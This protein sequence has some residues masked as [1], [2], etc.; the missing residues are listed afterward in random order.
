MSGV[1]VKWSLSDSS[2]ATITS[3]GLLG[4]TAEGQVRV[5]A[6]VE[7]VADS[8][9][10]A[11]GPAVATV[12][13]SP[14]P[15]T[16][17]VGSS[18]QL[19]AEAKSAAGATVPGLVAEWSVDDPS[20]A[21]I[22]AAGLVTALA[23]GTV[24]V[25]ARIGGVSDAL[26][27]TT[28]LP[29][30]ATIEVSPGNDTLPPG[31][32]LT[33]KTVVRTATGDVI[34]GAP[35]T[36]SSSDESLLSVDAA[37]VV[38]ARNGGSA[39]VTVTSGDVVG[40]ASLLIP[41]PC[42]AEILLNLNAFRLPFRSGSLIHQTSTTG[43]GTWRTSPVLFS[44][45]LVIGTS[46]ATTVLGTDPATLAGDFAPTHVCILDGNPQHTFSR[47]LVASGS[48]GPAN[49]RITQETFMPTSINVV[50]F[51]Y[52][53]LNTG[54]APVN[55]LRVG[56]VAD[57]DLGLGFSSPLE[58]FAYMRPDRTVV[59]VQKQDSVGFP[60]VFGMFSQ[61]TTGSPTAYVWLNGNN[62]TKA[63]FYDR[64]GNTGMTDPARG[65]V[66][67]MVGRSTYSL[68]PGETIRVYFGLVG[69]DSRAAFEATL[70]EAL[71]GLPGL[72]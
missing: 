53:I 58:D 61:A 4:A 52:S 44:A 54:T 41:S 42:A 7:A 51:R 18:V 66:R 28:M 70:Q 20:K 45:G 21:T 27:L 36:F 65:E 1:T 57:W 26:S 24:Q 9:T 62:L 69:G 43:S 49:L 63:Q 12:T 60:H 68:A 5:R 13:I 32:R 30:P 6:T 40:T 55:G 29:V 48:T 23:A 14:R 56:I 16:L 71:L 35:V 38:T 64:L 10:V 3:Q 59:E 47:M 31:T 11:V 37:G 33:L 2:R 15:A 67:A 19:A 25:T 34:P 46:A 72:P 39:T 17:V 8:F 22:S 50:V